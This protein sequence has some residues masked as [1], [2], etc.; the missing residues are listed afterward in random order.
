MKTAEQEEAKA[1]KKERPLVFDLDGTLIDS[2]DDIAAA[3]NATL[4]EFSRPTVDVATVSSWVGNGAGWLLEQ[5]FSIS[6]EDDSFA[7]IEESF[8]KHYL[9]NA[10]QKGRIMPGVK[11]LL[12]RDW[13]R[14]RAICTNKPQI[15][16]DSVMKE[17]GW[18]KHFSIILGASPALPKKPDG[19]MLEAIAQRW[20][21][22]PDQLVMIGDGPQDILAAHAVGAH[23]IGVRGGILAEE[24][25]LAAQ[26]DA[27][28]S[29]LLDL[30]A[31]LQEAG[32]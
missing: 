27:V 4:S 9:C 24:K 2:R 18:Q 20:D 1:M 32:L 3:C 26:P 17:L 10:W 5:A 13:A 31:Y 12:S 25:M 6:R 8:Q 7:A 11:E 16:T 28:L 22:A 29:S 15:V 14:Q 21:V 23:A 30:P 19:A